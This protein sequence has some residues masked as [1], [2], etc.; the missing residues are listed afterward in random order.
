MMRGSQIKNDACLIELPNVI[1]FRGNLTFAEFERHI[2]FEAKRYFIV[3]QVPL[4]EVRGEHAHKKCHQFLVCVR[5]RLSVIGDNGSF[6]VEYVLDRPNV[7][8][9]M[10]PMTWGTQYKYSPDA[11]LLV[12][13]SHYYDP[14]DYIRDYDEFLRLVR[15]GQ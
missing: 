10:P 8:F 13:A 12:F 7:G 11:V 5:G 6:Q 14:D 15:G 9:Y 2:P 3:Y 4:V 1:D